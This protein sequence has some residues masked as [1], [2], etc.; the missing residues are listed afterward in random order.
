MSQAVFVADCW[1]LTLWCLAR[2]CKSI[3]TDWPTDLPLV[4]HAFHLP[5]L[6]SA[7]EVLI[8]V[9]SANWVGPAIPTRMSTAPSI[10]H[11]TSKAPAP[12]VPV[13][14]RC[15]VLSKGFQWTPMPR[16]C[17]K[18]ALLIP[19]WCF[20]SFCTRGAFSKRKTGSKWTCCYIE[21]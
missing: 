1:I 7:V 11:A 8:T 18:T 13:R 14:W 4:G 17:L 2:A 20:K 10:A 19:N 16:T 15:L 9:A 21:T 12:P 3:W 5:L 6:F